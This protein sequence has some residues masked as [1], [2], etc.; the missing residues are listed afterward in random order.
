LI[1]GNRVTSKHWTALALVVLTAVLVPVVLTAVWWSRLPDPVA[2]HWSGSGLA[3][4][5][6]P[7]WLFA[8]LPL[9]MSALLLAG[10]LPIGDGERPQFLRF[11]AASVVLAGAVSVSALIANV[12]AES[13]IYVRLSSAA[14]VVAFALSALAFA[15]LWLHGRRVRQR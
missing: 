4:N 9:G 15:G 6:G 8:A 12:G 11:V 2:V 1:G 7:R 13:W 5:S 10:F 3:D 14:I